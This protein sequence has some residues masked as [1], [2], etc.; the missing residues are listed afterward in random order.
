MRSSRTLITILTLLIFTGIQ[1]KKESLG[2]PPET[3]SG[4][5]TVGFK[6]NGHIVVPRDHHRH[7]GLFYR[8]GYMG[9]QQGG[10]WHLYLSVRNWVSYPSEGID[11]QS[12]SLLLQEGGTYPFILGPNNEQVIGTVSAFCEY[13]DK[14]YAKL[15]TDSGELHITK[16]DEQNRILSGTF[17]FT[18]TDISSGEKVS[19]TD[20]RFDIRY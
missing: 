6:I 4:A 2:L 7:P 17:F 5:M 10:G 11:I 19:V 18:A 15:L 9:P 12:D 1:C 16:S 13:N 14:Y 8:Y 3:Q 20:G